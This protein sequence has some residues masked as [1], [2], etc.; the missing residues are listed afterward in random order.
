[1]LRK[2]TELLLQKEDRFNT[3]LQ[4]FSKRISNL[5]FAYPSVINSG[6]LHID[7]IIDLLKQENLVNSKNQYILDIGAANGEMVEL[8]HR[9]F[10]KCPIY[11]FEPRSEDFEQLKAKFENNKD[12][13]IINKALGTKISKTK[14]NTTNRRASSS[15]LEVN[16]SIN[17]TFL[18]ENIRTI[19][20]EDI[21]ISTLDNE[22]PENTKISL[23]KIDVQGYELEVFKGGEKTLKNTSMILV[24]M[25]NH[26]IYKGAPQYFE[27]DE[28]LRH[29]G[30]SLLEIIPSIR[31]NGKLY[32]WDAIYVNSVIAAK[33]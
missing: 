15:L 18:A 14:I 2:I 4:A 17:D 32:E 11:A 24:E 3:A 19:E 5:Y 27:I 25:Q 10:P 20:Q 28:H 13:T 12:I 8:F 30:F 29:Q 16:K 21:Q 1:M 26:Q 6:Y 7:R 31:R 22:I 23:I 9:Q 33:F